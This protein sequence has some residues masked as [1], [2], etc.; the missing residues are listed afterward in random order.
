MG[1]DEDHDRLPMMTREDYDRIGQILREIGGPSVTWGSQAHLD[2]WVAEHQ[3]RAERLTNARLAYATW[4][5]FFATA[6]LVAATVALVLVTV[7]VSH[8]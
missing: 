4:A 1:T 3:I 6:V 7:A 5:L 8:H 2:V